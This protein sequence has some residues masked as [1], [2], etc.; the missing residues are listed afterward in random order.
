MPPLPHHFSRFLRF[1]SMKITTGAPKTDVTVLML[2]S[3]GERTVRAI[4]S[5][6]MQKTAPP[7]N[8]A[9]ITTRLFEVRRSR[10][11]K[12]GTAIPTK[13]TGP[14]KAVTVAE[15]RLER[16]IKSGRKIFVF[17]PMD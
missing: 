16:R 9:G 13:E 10:L 17:T 6:M 4:R 5:D 8:E 11:T 12:K 2:S 7:K 15:S 3:I 1:T 14:A